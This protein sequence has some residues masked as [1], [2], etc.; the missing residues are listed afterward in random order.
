MF[1]LTFHQRRGTTLVELLMFTAF[2]A[3]SSSMFIMFF[4]STSEQRVRQQLVST[5]EQSGIQIMQTL[6]NRIRSAERVLDPVAAS[7]GNVLA[8]Q[9]SDETYNPTIIG[10]SGSVLY[11]A[12][13]NEIKTLSAESIALSDFSIRNTS[14]AEARES[15]LVQ[16]TITQQTDITT[17]LEYSRTFEA[18]ISLFPDD[19]ESTQCGCE[20]PQCAVNTYQ[21]Q[22]CE[23]ET[24]ADADVYLPC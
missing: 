22:Y 3:I 4:I 1:V 21:W 24:C 14:V 16:F 7:S 17:T 10:L 12:E 15:V 23:S 11:A 9:L 19:V 5:V 18:A 6:S 20:S 2:F 8:L 13:A